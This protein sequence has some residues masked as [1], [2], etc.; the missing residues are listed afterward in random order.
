MPG[1]VLN[2]TLTFSKDRRLNRTGVVLT[3][4]LPENTSFDPNHSDP[5]WTQ[6]GVSDVYTYPFGSLDPVL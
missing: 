2:Y 4:T 1:E 5:G 3:D 6:A